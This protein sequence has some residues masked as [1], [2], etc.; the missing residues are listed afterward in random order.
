MN[1]KEK[2]LKEDF[3]LF[4]NLGLNETQHSNLLKKLLTVSGKHGQGD[5]FLKSFLDMIKLSYS[6]E[7]WE[8]QK[9]QK[10][11]VKGR[12]DLLISSNKKIVIVE[13]KIRNADN[14]KNQL[15]RYWKNAILDKGFEESKIIYLARS[16]KNKDFEKDLSDSKSKPKNP[17]YDKLIGLP[18]VLEHKVDILG[19]KE[20]ILPWL[21]GCLTKI[22]DQNNPIASNL[23]LIIMLE[24]Y[25]E[26][27]EIHL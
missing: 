12:I 9:E 26:Y 17:T 27:I 13:N 20:D 25:I 18:N 3:N 10:A 19:Y 8:I 16:R 1:A 2:N 22:S 15:Y 4:K 11:G 7:K 14:Q 23:R 5:M 21:K 24:Q 6:D